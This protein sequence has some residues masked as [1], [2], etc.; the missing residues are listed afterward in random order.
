MIFSKKIKERIKKLN[1][2]PYCLICRF[3]I[4]SLYYLQVKLK[5]IQLQFRYTI[6]DLKKNK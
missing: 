5:K 6:S 2:N 1:F 4:D 3:D